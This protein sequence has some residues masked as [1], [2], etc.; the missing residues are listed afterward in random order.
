MES[1]TKIC[2]LFLWALWI[3]IFRELK[4][5]IGEIESYRNSSVV[6]YCERRIEAKVPNIRLKRQTF[7]QFFILR[8]ICQHGVIEN[9]NLWVN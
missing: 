2:E 7:N 3:K 6:V 9:Y 4:K 1:A 8:T 5:R